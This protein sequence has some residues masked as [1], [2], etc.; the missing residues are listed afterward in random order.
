MSTINQ[1]A[2][3]LERTGLPT[4]EALEL[5]QDI[6]R[7]V[8]DVHPGIV[9]GGTHAEVVPAMWQRARS[10]GAQSLTL[11]L[12]VDDDGYHTRISVLERLERPQSWEGGS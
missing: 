7:D 6:V 9:F 12:E 4:S 10:S 8:N 2:E 11:K 1:L 3:L 5:A